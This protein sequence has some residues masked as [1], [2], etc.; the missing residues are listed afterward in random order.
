VKLNPK[1]EMPPGVIRRNADNIRGLLAIADKC[2]SEWGRRVREAL[3]FLLAKAKSERPE[4]TMVRHGLMI[5]DTPELDQI[6]S[7]RFNRELK[8]LDLPDANWT[9]YR[10]SGGNDYA[11]PITMAEQSAAGKGRHS[12]DES[13]A[14]GREAMPR[15]QARAI[16]GG[17]AQVRCRGAGRDRGR[18]RAAATGQAPVRLGRHGRHTCHGA[19]SMQVAVSPK[20]ILQAIEQLKVMCED[21]GEE[22]PLDP[23]NLYRHLGALLAGEGP[24]ELVPAKIV[25]VGAQSFVGIE[26]G[27]GDDPEE[28][29]AMSR[30]IGTPESFQAAAEWGFVLYRDFFGEEPSDGDEDGYLTLVVSAHELLRTRAARI[31]M[32]SSPLS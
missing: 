19:N 24:A 4:V 15:L 1:P 5:F 2:G 29:E 31:A 27:V 8:R 18:P 20:A 32:H 21:Y 17:A 10:G 6:G 23:E 11:H 25:E 13:P 22:F 14:T 26:M 30:P 3:T 16:R 9:G 12:L 7:V 28:A